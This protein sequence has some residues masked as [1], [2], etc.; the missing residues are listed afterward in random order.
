MQINQPQV[1]PTVVSELYTV[2][3]VCTRLNICRVTA[4]KLFKKGDLQMIKIGAKTLVPIKSVDDLLR[5]SGVA[6]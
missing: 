2:R 5:K 3:D 1:S 6:A 4:Y